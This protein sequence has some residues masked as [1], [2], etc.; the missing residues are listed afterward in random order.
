[1]VLIVTTTPTTTTAN[2]RLMV[3]VVAYSVGV[4]VV[5]F[6]FL[7]GRSLAVHLAQSSSSSSPSSSLSSSLSSL[8]S[9]S[10]SSSPLPS[11]PPWGHQ[12]PRHL[13]LQPPRLHHHHH[14][15]YITD[16]TPPL[17]PTGR[18]ATLDANSEDDIKVQVPASSMRL[19]SLLIL[20]FLNS[21][22]R[23]G[24][25]RHPQ[26]D[27]ELKLVF[28]VTIMFGLLL[29]CTMFVLLSSCPESSPGDLLH[30]GCRLSIHLNY[31]GFIS[32]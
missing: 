29:G 4:R 27:N 3:C 1:M 14:Q 9:S 10:L 15:Q 30:E 22:S 11:S 23:A 18:G 25:K 7:S 12:Q 31:T 16:S 28:A 5:I 13:R 6:T 21:H 2:T 17:P 8:L 24:P 19:L 20:P 26:R 32:G